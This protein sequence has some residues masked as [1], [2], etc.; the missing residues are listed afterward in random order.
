MKKRLKRKIVEKVIMEVVV[1]KSLILGI[2][3]ENFDK[4]LLVPRNKLDVHFGFISK[5]FH[6]RNACTA[7]HL[8]L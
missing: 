4:T 3:I 8:P 6:Q 7:V 1:R 5:S 2:A